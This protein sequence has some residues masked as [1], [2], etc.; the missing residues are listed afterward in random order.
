MR[1]EQLL[2][3]GHGQADW[4]PRVPPSPGHHSGQRL[5]HLVA[6]WATSIWPM[7]VRPDERQCSA[8]DRRHWHAPHLRLL[9]PVRSRE[10]PYHDNRQH[11]EG[12]HCLRDRQRHGLVAK[13][14]QLAPVAHR[15][16]D[17]RRC[18]ARSTAPWCLGPARG[19]AGLVA[20]QRCSSMSSS[21]ATIRAPSSS[22]PARAARMGRGL[23]STT[24]SITGE[25]YPT[26]RHE[27]S[28]PNDAAGDARGRFSFRSS[29]RGSTLDRQ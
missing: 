29:Q 14:R 20:T 3:G 7:S 9:L 22:P 13:H 4:P 21:T 16:V 26:Q 23:H 15:A 8:E 28:R 18:R 5:A 12:C 19:T 24:I 10:Q 2:L 17:F 27:E 1:S 6:P 11:R 25:S